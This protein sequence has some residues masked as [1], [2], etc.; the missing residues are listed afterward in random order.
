[1][2]FER[3]R[4]SYLEALRA[5]LPVYVVESVN[6]S[7]ARGASG[8]DHSSGSRVGSS[9]NEAVDLHRRRMENVSCA[10]EL[11][12]VQ[13]EKGRLRTLTNAERLS[14]LEQEYALGCLR[15]SRILDKERI[16]ELLKATD[17]EKGFAATLRATPTTTS[18]SALNLRRR[19]SSLTVAAAE[20]EALCDTEDAPSPELISRLQALVSEMEASVTAKEVQMRAALAARL[21]ER[22]S[23]EE[24]ASRD[25]WESSTK[26]T[27]L[28]QRLRS[29]EERLGRVVLDFLQLRHCSG[30]AGRKAIEEEEVVRA[31]EAQH[32][33]AARSARQ[34]L[35]EERLRLRD[36]AKNAARGEAEVLRHQLRLRRSEI[37][38][39]QEQ[40]EEARRLFEARV[41]AL[42]DK[43]VAWAVKARASERRARLEAEGFRRASEELARRLDKAQT[44]W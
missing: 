10:R 44:A 33:E 42:Q 20:T 28:Q 40:Q 29:L 18:N 4:E 7:I 43:D 34:A 14:N 15:L 37:C 22:A 39:L 19:R 5:M 21:S 36:A 17:P 3:E 26:V 1:M 27:Q 25:A 9:E 12:R 24:K 6:G 16:V 38:L 8:H 41:A 32:R 30:V 13:V 11:W 23:R 31:G 35:L 2:D